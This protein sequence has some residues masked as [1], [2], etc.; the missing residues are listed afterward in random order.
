VVYSARYA[1][2]KRNEWATLE[3]TIYNRYTTIQQKYNTAKKD[4]NTVTDKK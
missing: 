1:P 2:S 3:S 4:D